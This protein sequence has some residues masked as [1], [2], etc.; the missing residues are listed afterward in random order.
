[1]LLEDF[2]IDGGKLLGKIWVV[3]FAN[4]YLH[5]PNSYPDHHLPIRANELQVQFY[6]KVDRVYNICGESQVPVRKFWHLRPDATIHTVASLLIPGLATGRGM[7]PPSEQC[8][9]VCDCNG[10]CC[11]L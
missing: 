11:L 5:E 2:T 7:V 4:S 9:A 6:F 10:C 1:M 3:A 8:V